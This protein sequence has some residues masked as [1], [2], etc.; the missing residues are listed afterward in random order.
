MGIVNQLKYVAN[1]SIDIVYPN[2]CAVCDRDLVQNEHHICLS[3]LYDLPYLSSDKK[4]DDK[5][6]KLFWGRVEVE[7]IYALFN[8]QKGNQVQDILHLI[9]YKNK[10]KLAEY[11]GCKLAACMNETRHIDYVLP[12]PLHPKKKRKRGYNQSTIIANGITKTL[13]IPLNESLI[14]RVHHNPSQTIFSKFDRWD[15][16]RS[17]FEVIDIKRL[18]GKHVLLVDDVMTTGATIEACVKQLVKVEDC[19][20]SVAT[21]AAR[22]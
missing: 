6:N 11:L 1:A 4:N 17:I 7:K 8:Y 9:K 18:K 22:V 14:K 2:Y 13:G 19:K 5:L 12:V 16:V 20:V 21:L 10:T 15:N 3:C